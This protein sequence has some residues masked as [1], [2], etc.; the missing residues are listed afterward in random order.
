MADELLLKSGSVQITP[1]MARFGSTSYQIANI[2]SVT[3]ESVRKWNVFGVCLL[4]VSVVLGVWGFGIQGTRPDQATNLWL[5]TAVVVI[6]AM[7]IQKIW[8][9]II[10]TVILKTSSGDIQALSS[11]DRGHVFS[12][13]HALEDAFVRRT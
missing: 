13:Q 2:G 10:Y 9:Q 1:K 6:G 4:V 11:K 12:V 3:V 7:V 8:P 5:A